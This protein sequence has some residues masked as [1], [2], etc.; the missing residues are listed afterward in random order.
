MTTANLPYAFGV[1]NQDKLNLLAP[2][3][4]ADAGVVGSPPWD[5]IFPQTPKDFEEFLILDGEAQGKLAEVFRSY[6]RPTHKLF[7]RH[8]ADVEKAL[9]GFKYPNEKKGVV[10]S[11][12]FGIFGRD[13][14]YDFTYG[15]AA[16]EGYRKLL[17]IELVLSDDEYEVWDENHRPM[18]YM[19]ASAE[20]ETLD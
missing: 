11:Y 20:F 18:G 16:Y 8:F 1:E 12:L 14:G 5:E 7:V 9:M 3:I 2:Y 19:S 17:D 4:G 15:L 6:E 13:A 10:W